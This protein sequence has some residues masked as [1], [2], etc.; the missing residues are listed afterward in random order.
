MSIESRTRLADR[1]CLGFYFNVQCMYGA[2]Q[3]ILCST[4]Q[5]N[6]VYK[7]IFEILYSLFRDSVYL[8]QLASDEAI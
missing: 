6:Y 4:I 3:T 5:A 2:K 8:D 1:Q 7:F